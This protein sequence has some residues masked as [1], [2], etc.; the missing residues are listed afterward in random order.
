MEFDELRATGAVG[1]PRIRAP[2]SP[3]DGLVVSRHALRLD[4]HRNRGAMHLTNATL[5]RE[6]LS[7]SSL[8]QDL[9]RS[10]PLANVV[11]VDLPTSGATAGTLARRMSTH[12]AEFAAA[13]EC[14]G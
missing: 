13:P 11:A 2:R 5:E 7:S 10:C 14:D 8:A 1:I 9:T 6:L 3:R 12:H 4:E